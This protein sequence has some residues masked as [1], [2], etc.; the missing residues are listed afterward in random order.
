MLDVVLRNKK[1]SAT[2]RSTILLLVHRFASSG[3]VLGP[4]CMLF[5]LFF[6]SLLQNRKK[7][8]FFLDLSRAFKGSPQGQKS[9]ILPAVDSLTPK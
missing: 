5:V 4:F 9:K 3:A 6:M 7:K 2:Y 1:V 8:I